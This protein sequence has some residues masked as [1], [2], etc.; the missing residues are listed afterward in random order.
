MAAGCR[1]HVR[2]ADALFC[3]KAINAL[4]IGERPSA[5]AVL[6][7]LPEFASACSNYCRASTSSRVYNTVPAESFSAESAEQYAEQALQF[8]IID[9]SMESGQLLVEIA[10]AVIRRIHKRH[11]PST[12]AAKRLARALIEKLCRDCLW[13]IDRDAKAV[14]AVHLSFALLGS[15]LNV[16]ELSPINLFTADAFN[17]NENRSPNQFDAIVNNPPWGESLRRAERFLSPRAIQNA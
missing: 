1:E 10:R 15:E 13:G 6:F 16:G 7:E 9:P 14:D 17:W 3:T 5:Q 2:D 8:R 11:S 4:W 12:K